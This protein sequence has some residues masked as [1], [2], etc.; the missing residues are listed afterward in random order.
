MADAIEV[1]GLRAGYG[2][3]A[4]ALD[5]VAFTVRDAGLAAVI[6]PN[7]SGKSTLLKVLAGLL[8]PE[9]GRVSVR[10]A[11]PARERPKL[12]AR[13]I[14]YL[15]QGEPE[16]APFAALD[17]VLMGRFPYQGLLPFDRAE[18]LE[19]AR[20]CLGAVDALPLAGRLLSEMSGGERQRVHLARALA[21]EP[22]VLLL[23]EPAA[24]LDLRHQVSAWSLLRRLQAQDRRTVVAVSHD[25][26]LPAD[27]ADQVLVLKGGRIVASGPPAEVLRASVLEP[28]YETR[29]LEARVAGR[30]LPVLIP[31]AAP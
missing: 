25:L 6:G 11:D 31:S 12:R 22:E 15:P 7:G 21:Q 14:A 9:A 10:G 20:R 23:D 19:V 27:F 29:L 26:N 16:D 2:G 4:P 28:V 3:G 24:A 8:R 17:L 18:D 30:D 5:G 13:R 1:T